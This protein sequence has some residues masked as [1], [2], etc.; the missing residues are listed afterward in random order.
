VQSY[1]GRYGKTAVTTYYDEPHGTGRI[2]A[3]HGEVGPRNNVNIQESAILFAINKVRRERVISRKLLDEKQARV[4]I[5][6]ND[7]CMVGDSREQAHRVNAAEMVNICGTRAWR[8]SCQGDATVGTTKVAAAT[9]SFAR[10]SRTHAGR[11][12]FSLQNYPVANPLPTTIPDDMPLMRNVTV[13][14]AD[15]Q[16]RAERRGRQ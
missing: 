13:A 11:S 1:G 10:I 6:K 8:L 7:L 9:T 4:D 2:R 14:Q 3:A 5:G 12:Y 16:E 15:R